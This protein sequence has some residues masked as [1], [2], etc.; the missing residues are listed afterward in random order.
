MDHYDETFAYRLLPFCLPKL[1]EAFMMRRFFLEFL[2]YMK[3]AWG[4][5]GERIGLYTCFG[6]LCVSLA[7]RRQ[8]LKHVKVVRYYS[9]STSAD[10]HKYSAIFVGPG[11]AEPRAGNHIGT[12]NGEL[13]LIFRQLS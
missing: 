10:G 2:L 12:S 11:G 6:E 3:A 8:C 9:L 4:R 13:M 5:H 1:L 7:R